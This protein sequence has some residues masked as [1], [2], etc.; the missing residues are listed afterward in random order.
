MTISART[1]I[2]IRCPTSLLKKIGWM[3]AS[4]NTA[5]QYHGCYWCGC[6]CSLTKATEVEHPEQQKDRRERTK[7]AHEYFLSIDIDL[8]EIKE[9]EWM[10]KGK[11][12]IMLSDS[13]SLVDYICIM[14]VNGHPCNTSPMQLHR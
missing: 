13:V 1:G 9:C 6:Q 7:D 2:F 4:T 8:V 11:T 10:N 5:Y 14:D 3:D 12:Q